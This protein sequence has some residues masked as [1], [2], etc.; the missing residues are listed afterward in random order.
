MN[1]LSSWL[2]SSQDSTQV[3]NKVK[4]VILFL[5]STIILLVGVFFHIQLSAS[6]ILTLASELGAVA[7]AI[8]TIYGSILHLVT[9]WSSLPKS[10]SPAATYLPPTD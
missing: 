2:Q 8:W 6:D 3:A 7:G 9:W 5:S 4:G 10:N 1:T